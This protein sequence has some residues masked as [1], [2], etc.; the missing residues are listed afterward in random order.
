MLFGLSSFEAQFGFHTVGSIDHHC[1]FSPLFFM[2]PFFSFFFLASFFG[3]GGAVSGGTGYAV[4]VQWSK[5][6]GGGCSSGVGFSFIDCME[7]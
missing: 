5:L 4:L 2:L 7:L 3:W 1:L 6:V